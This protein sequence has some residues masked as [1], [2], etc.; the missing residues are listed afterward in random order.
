MDILL[1]NDS[2]SRRRFLQQMA[3]MGAGALA[4]GSPVSVLA[5]TGH[6]EPLQARVN[7]YVKGL[8]RKGRVRSDEQTSWSVYDLSTGTKLVSINEGVQRQAASM[9]KPFVAQAYFFRHQAAP[10]RYP[11]SAEVE[12]LITAMIRRSNNHATNE[13]IA[14]VSSKAWSQR[15]KAVEQ[16]LRQNADGIFRDTAIVEYIP[17][18]GRTYRNKASARDYSRFLYAMWHDQLP[19]SDEMEYFL[20]LPNADRI[21]HGTA[22]VPDNCKVLDKTGSTAHLCGNMGIVVARGRDG[23]TYPYT[24]I[25]IIE[26]QKRPKSYGPW[27]RDRGNVIRE[28]SDIVYADMRKRHNLL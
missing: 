11:Y 26:K 28:V 13:M 8:R 23:K 16:V 21:R 27:I 12:R 18:G 1:D 24:M 19:M 15:P 2:S 9:I 3:A 17:K 10:S 4:L 22:R 14:R 20:G 5:K 6:S 25:G 7:A